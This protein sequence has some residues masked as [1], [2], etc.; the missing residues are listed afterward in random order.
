M[1]DLF[2][3]FSDEHH[4]S[5][6]DPSAIEHLVQLFEVEAYKAWAAAEL[7]YETDSAVKET[8]KETETQQ[9]LIK[10][11]NDDDKYFQFESAME[12]AMEEFRRFEEEMERLAS[13]ELSSL[14]RAGEAAKKLGNL[15][16]KAA[17]FASKKYVEA[18]M[19]SAVASMR[20]AW[21]GIYSQKVHPS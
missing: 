8:E 16:E 3:F 15:M 19:N 13:T 14:V 1:E 12:S 18:A 11:N 17:S 20:S 5:I 9:P 21:R 6:V 7:N 2:T 4:T 10:A